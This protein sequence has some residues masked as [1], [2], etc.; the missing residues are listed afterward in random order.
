MISFVTFTN[1]VFYLL[2][3]ESE[4]LHVCG[5]FVGLFVGASPVVSPTYFQ[6]VTFIT[7]SKDPV[8][9]SGC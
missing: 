1:F 4:H 5:P 7:V 6:D 2:R 8:P 9:Q 3:P